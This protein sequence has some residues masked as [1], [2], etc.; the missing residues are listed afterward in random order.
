MRSGDLKAAQEA[1]Q[2]VKAAKLWKT[3][4][5]GNK[6]GARNLTQPQLATLQASYEKAVLAAIAPVVKVYVENLQ[7][8]KT[9]FAGQGKLDEAVLIVG[10]IKE[11]LAG[12]AL[13]LDAA[14]KG[15]LSGM[16]KLEFG[17]WLPGQVFEFSGAISGRTLLK[18]TA[19][20]V[21]YGGTDGSPN[22]E[23]EL[24]GN[25]KLEIKGGLSKRGFEMELSRDLQAGG[26]RSVRGEYALT[27]N[28]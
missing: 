24:V 1:Q 3:V 4:P 25:R 26:F 18:I 14:A 23:Y 9:N 16:S 19:D 20:K 15:Y 27:V 11:V 5:V 12:N 28:P 21:N 2:E 10:E 7:R 8:L 6:I 13:P 17:E 22:Y